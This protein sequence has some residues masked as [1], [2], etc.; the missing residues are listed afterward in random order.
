VPTH[1]GGRLGGGGGG[2]VAV[3]AEPEVL[4]PKGSAV[5]RLATAGACPYGGTALDALRFSEHGKNPFCCGGSAYRPTWF[6]E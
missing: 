1:L 4:G 6:G 5:Q 3:I 2:V